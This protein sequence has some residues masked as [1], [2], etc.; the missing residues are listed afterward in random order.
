MQLGP[1]LRSDVAAVQIAQQANLGAVMEVF[2]DD[3]PHELPHWQHPVPLRWSFDIELIVRERNQPGFVRGW[4]RCARRAAYRA[5]APTVL[6]TS[7]RNAA[8]RLSRGRS[9]AMLRSFGWVLIAVRVENEGEASATN[10]VPPDFALH[11][12]GKRC[13][14]QSGRSPLISPHIDKERTI[15]QEHKAR[16]ICRIGG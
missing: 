1:R 5:R 6:T 8:R 12:H 11:D 4:S 9:T 10:I 3:R 14:D 7:W 16:L 15:S 13:N 2:G